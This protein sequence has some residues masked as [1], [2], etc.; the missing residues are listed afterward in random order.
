MN[1]PENKKQHFYRL[2]KQLNLDKKAKE[3]KREDLTD[4]EGYVNLDP[5]VLVESSK[6]LLDINRGDAE[7]DE[8]DSLRY[9][10]IHTPDQLFRERIKLDSSKVSK[11]L[12]KKLN[13]QKSLKAVPVNAFDKYT[14]NLLTGS[15]LSTPLE[16]INPLHLTEQKRRITQMGEGGLSSSESITQE[17]QNVHPHEFGFIDTLAGPESERAGV[18]T[19]AAWG[20]K[21]GDDGLLYQKFRDRRTGKYV[22]LSPKDLD[23]KVLGLPE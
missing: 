6:K 5:N 18:D 4:S 13:S 8:R 15:A 17:A 1:S 19:R 12:M 3:K 11:N 7:P 20:T 9:K 14:E 10:R 2:K 21:I 22:W 16:E 23:G